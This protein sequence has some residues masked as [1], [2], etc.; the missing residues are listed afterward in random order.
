MTNYKF[1]SEHNASE[2]NEGIVLAINQYSD[3]TGEE[4]LSK[5]TGLII[6]KERAERMNGFTFQAQEV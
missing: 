2:D 3:M 1:I 4:F 5:N 6:P